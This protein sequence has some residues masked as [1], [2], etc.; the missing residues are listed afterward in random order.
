MPC[1][2]LETWI[3]EPPD[4]PGTACQLA[5]LGDAVNTS[6]A[7]GPKMKDGAKNLFNVLR[8]RA[9]GVRMFP[10]FLGVTREEAFAAEALIIRVVWK[11]PACRALEWRLGDGEQDPDRKFPMLVVRIEISKIVWFCEMV[12][13]PT[14]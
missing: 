4:P 12:K 8:R 13:G 2:T 14:S 9:A 11:S 7:G 3:F 10:V 5:S 1:V 6:G